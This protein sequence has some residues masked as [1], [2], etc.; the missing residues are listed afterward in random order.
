[1]TSS[2]ERQELKQAVIQALTPS[3]LNCQERECNQL[4]WDEVVRVSDFDVTQASCCQAKVAGPADPFVADIFKT[5]RAIALR[6]AQRLK[7][8]SPVTTA[9][10]TVMK[11]ARGTSDWIGKYLDTSAE[12]V[13]IQTATHAVSWLTRTSELLETSD[14]SGFRADQNLEWRYPGYGLMLRSKIPLVDGRDGAAI[15]VLVTT[16]PSE[17]WDDAVA[18]A[19]LLWRLA[20]TDPSDHL[21][22]LIHS[23][24]ER[25]D[26]AIDPLLER[27]LAAAT[28]AALAV[29]RRG[30]GPDGLGR[31]PSFF[32]CQSCAWSDS[33]V[34]RDEAENRPSVRGGIRLG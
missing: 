32:T 8:P 28:R 34:E 19:A 13:R 1:M 12:T 3:A 20:R 31:V 24:G 16:S 6:A 33:C 9:V 7:G 14:F 26:L 27:G 22:V 2:D 5:Y 4:E 23:T 21:A 29:S 11:K 10:S 17:A 25:F 30:S 15:P 18:Y